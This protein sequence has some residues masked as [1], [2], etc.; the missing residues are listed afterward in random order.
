M[1]PVV[2]LMSLW[3]SI[4][5]TMCGGIPFRMASV[6]K[7]LLQ[8]W[9]QNAGGLPSGPVMRGEGAV[10]EAADS[11]DDRGQ[12]VGQFRVDDGVSRVCG[13]RE[14]CTAAGERTTRTICSVMA[15]VRMRRCDVAGRQ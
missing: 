2:V 4:S 9:G 1:Q 6:V 8:S 12:D 15:V 13:F 5:W 7:T 11:G 3:P 14:R 10:Q